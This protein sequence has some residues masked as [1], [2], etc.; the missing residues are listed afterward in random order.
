MVVENYLLFGFL[1][2]TREVLVLPYLL[3]R[4]ELTETPRR[5]VAR[6]SAPFADIVCL[7]G[8]DVE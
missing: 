5:D 1:P 7:L 2:S 6:F 3:Q 4:G 8:Y